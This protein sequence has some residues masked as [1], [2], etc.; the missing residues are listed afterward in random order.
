MLGIPFG[1]VRSWWVTRAGSGLAIGASNR[2]LLVNG[3]WRRCPPSK[4]LA[5]FVVELGYH[6]FEIFY[7]GATP[8]EPAGKVRDHEDFKA[9]W[10]HPA[11]LMLEASGVLTVHHTCP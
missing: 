4:V 7:E 3:R 8:G 10:R 2:F 11:T 1:G 9:G 5:D 6:F